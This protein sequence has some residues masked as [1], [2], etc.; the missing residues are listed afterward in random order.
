MCPYVRVCVWQFKWHLPE[1]KT[2][3]AHYIPG[4]DV[5]NGIVK[6]IEALNALSREEVRHSGRHGDGGWDG[7]GGVRMGWG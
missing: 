2:L 4:E 6:V 3:Y 5:K 1:N 7:G